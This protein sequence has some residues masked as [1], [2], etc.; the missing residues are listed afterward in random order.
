MS[1]HYNR[2]AKT[3][4]MVS[5]SLAF[6]IMGGAGAK[7]ETQLLTDFLES[8][9]GSDMVAWSLPVDRMGLDEY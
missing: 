1:S 7:L 3:A 8:R 6:I 2:N 4:L 9:I 5:I